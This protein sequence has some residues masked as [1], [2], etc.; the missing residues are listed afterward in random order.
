MPTR[1]LVNNFLGAVYGKSLRLGKEGE[2]FSLSNVSY[3]NHTGADMS[4]SHRLILKQGVVIN[5]NTL[6]LSNES[7]PHIS[8]ISFPSNGCCSFYEL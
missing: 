6:C 3:P 4:S 8:E 1:S 5:I 7:L 2:I